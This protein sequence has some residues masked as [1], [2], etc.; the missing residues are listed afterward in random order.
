MGES[1]N[2]RADAET[3]KAGRHEKGSPSGHSSA[4]FTAVPAPRPHEADQEKAA[5]ASQP[6]LPSKPAS[7]GSA[8]HLKGRESEASMQQI[9]LLDR[10]ST[11]AL[12]KG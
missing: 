10:P 2:A 3:E 9:G 12:S 5:G 8:G 6:E 7:H 4:V 11:R 1:P